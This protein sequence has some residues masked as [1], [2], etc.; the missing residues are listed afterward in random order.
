[1][2]CPNSFFSRCCPCPGHLPH[3]STPQLPLSLAVV[4]D[5]PFPS[6]RL[7]LPSLYYY[8]H[9]RLGISPSS[10]PP[11]FLRPLSLS[12]LGMR[13]TLRPGFYPTLLAPPQRCAPTATGVNGNGHCTRFRCSFHCQ[14]LQLPLITKT[15]QLPPRMAAVFGKKR[16]R[17]L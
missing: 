15:Q 9:L 6:S 12:F 5:V 10:P 17:C 13:R 14:P 1:M 8:L 11:S 4:L 7:F 3:L 16:Y 2:C